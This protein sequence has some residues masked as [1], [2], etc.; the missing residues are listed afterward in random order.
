MLDFPLLQMLLVWFSINPYNSQLGYQILLLLCH[1]FLFTRQLIK[2][3]TTIS[4]LLYM[5]GTQFFGSLLVR[6]PPE[7]FISAVIFTGHFADIISNIVS[8]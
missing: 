1:V 2:Y 6:I 8:T 4:V 5:T 7:E 3:E